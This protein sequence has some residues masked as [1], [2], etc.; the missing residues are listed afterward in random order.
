MLREKDVE[1]TRLATQLKA[2]RAEA[3]G[4]AVSSVGGD[5]GGNGGG[6]G[7]GKGGG[8]SVALTDPP[9]PT[10]NTGSGSSSRTAH[11]AVSFA[12]EGSSD[13]SAQSLSCRVEYLAKAFKHFVLVTGAVERANLARVICQ[14]LCFNDSES[15]EIVDRASTFIVTPMGL[16][17]PLSMPSLESIELYSIEQFSVE[18][19]GA[20]LGS[21]FGFSNTP[22]PTPTPAPAPAHTRPTDT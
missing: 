9:P 4:L 3:R 8:R 16:Q 11:K 21:L 20:A 19:V 1:L 6:S 12:G 17:Q 13:G 5:R 14:L 22:T 10:P 2:T 7:S 15:K 18:N